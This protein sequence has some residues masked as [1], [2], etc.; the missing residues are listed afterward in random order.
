ME[1]FAVLNKS[2]AETSDDVDQINALIWEYV[3][4]ISSISHQIV[5]IQHGAENSATASEEV[6]A[7]IEE[8]TSLMNTL[9]LNSEKLMSEASMLV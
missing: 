9:D 4:Q 8:L 2:I 5:D 1:A 6:T 3:D 7:S